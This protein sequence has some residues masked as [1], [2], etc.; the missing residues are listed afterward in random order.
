MVIIT[1]QQIIFKMVMSI[2]LSII[3]ILL[4]L[5][6]YGHFYITVTVLMTMRLLVLLNMEIRMLKLS[7]I[8]LCMQEQNTSDL[9]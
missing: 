9:F 8:R 2:K 3:T 7:L 1:L 5:K 4:T 6:D